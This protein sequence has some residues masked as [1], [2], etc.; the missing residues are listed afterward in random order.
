MKKISFG[1]IAVCIFCFNANSQ[2]PPKKDNSGITPEKLESWVPVPIITAGNS[3]SDAPSDA[4]ILFNGKDLSAFQRKD[5]SPAKWRLDPEGTVT[6][7][8]GAGDLITKKAFGNCQ[9]HVE[10]RTPAEV[11]TV[12]KQEVIVA[13]TLWVSMRCKFWTPMIMLPTPMGKLL[14]FISNMRH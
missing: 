11:K 13:C 14:Q 3:N 4:I 6:D 7:I 8:K 10:F 9:L 2:N 12:V 1:F 5:G